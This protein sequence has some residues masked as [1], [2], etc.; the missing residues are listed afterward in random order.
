LRWHHHATPFL[1]T[2]VLLAP[3]PDGV[4]TLPKGKLPDRDD[5]THYVADLAVHVKVWYA[6]VSASAQLADDF[7]SWLLR[8]D[9]S[10]V[11]AL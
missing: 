3:D 10:Q 8:P 7:A 5:F 9:F 11:H 2:M 1:D 6:A 4:K